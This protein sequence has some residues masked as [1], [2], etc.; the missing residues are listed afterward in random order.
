MCIRDSLRD[1]DCRGFIED[2]DL[3]P[4]VEHLEDLD[5]LTRTHPEIGHQVIGL[6]VQ[7][8]GVGDPADLGAGRVPDAVQLLGAE[9]DVLCLLYTSRCV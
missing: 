2:E 8:I 9:D 3:R 6:D 7:A 1:Q 5:A 4:S